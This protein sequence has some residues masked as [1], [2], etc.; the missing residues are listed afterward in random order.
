[1]K[2]M[3]LHSSPPPSTGKATRTR[4]EGDRGTA[5]RGLAATASVA[6]MGVDSF[7]LL[8]VGVFLFSIIFRR[9][10]KLFFLRFYSFLGFLIHVIAIFE[11]LRYAFTIRLF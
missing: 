5:T 6:A 2:R 9:I 4:E 7:F 8:L 3:D 1:M 11:I 10:L